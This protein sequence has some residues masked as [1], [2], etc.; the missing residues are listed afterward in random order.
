[1]ANFVLFYTGGNVP[2]NAD[3]RAAF[4]QAWRTWFEG[5]G[6]NL[7]DGGHPFTPIVK[8]IGSDGSVMDGSLG[9]PATGYSILKAESLDAAVQMAKKCPVLQVDSQITVYEA[10]PVG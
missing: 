4:M 1:M 6:S 2:E 3:Q 10:Y 7:V 5:L 8:S 9:T